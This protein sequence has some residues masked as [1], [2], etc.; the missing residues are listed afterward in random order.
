MRRAREAS[1]LSL[2]EAATAIGY[3]QPVQ[4]SLMEN[5]LRLPPVLVLLKFA[6]VTGTTMDYLTGMADNVT[7][8]PVIQMQRAIAARVTAD[9][10]RLIGGMTAISV[11]V[12]RELRPDSG[13]MARL[14]GL[15]LEA[16]SALEWVRMRSPE[17]DDLQGGSRLV[18]KI[19]AA[20]A[21]ASEHAQA[22]ERAR[23][24]LRV[25]SSAFTFDC[26]DDEPSGPEGHSLN[27]LAPLSEQSMLEEG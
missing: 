26:L 19:V 14:A 25:C 5:G 20:G 22:E 8:D 12:V 16:V 11:D 1:G 15:A 7:P 13:R 4:L 24:A 27:P 9:M 23:R 10:R 18:A 3:S 2:T 6:Q 21:L 17:F